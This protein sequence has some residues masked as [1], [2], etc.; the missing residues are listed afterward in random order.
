V[1][2]YIEV[3]LQRK[4]WYGWQTLDTE[5]RSYSSSTAI[6]QN[7]DDYC[8]AGHYYFRGR[9]YHQS[10][11]TSGTYSATTYGAQSIEKIFQYGG[12]C[13]YE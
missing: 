11:E 9:T 8:T 4:R 3:K 7:T 6:S 2:L 5:T 1:G 10:S 12:S 13:I